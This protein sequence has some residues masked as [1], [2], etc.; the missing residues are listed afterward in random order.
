MVIE[1][2]FFASLRRYTPAD[3]SGIV[4]VD[5]TDG[6]SVEELLNQMEVAPAHVGSVLLNGQEGNL[7]TRLSDGDRLGLF[8]ANG[9]GSA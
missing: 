6:L 1:V 5:V 4:S 7:A 9:N 3:P 2:R 8:P